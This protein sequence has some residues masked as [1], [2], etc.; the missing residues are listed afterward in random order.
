MFVLQTHSLL[1]FER[2][3]TLFRS[4]RVMQRHKLLLIGSVLS[5]LALLVLWVMSLVKFLPLQGRNDV[6]LHFSITIGIDRVGPWY[7]LFTPAVV[8][9]IAVVSAHLIAARVAIKH[10]PF[11]ELALFFAVL[12]SFLSLASVLHLS[13]LN[14]GI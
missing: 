11:A 6:A 4:W 9:T 14:V 3:M 1:Y 5:L 2:V 7:W 13:L 12:I 8:G 10:P